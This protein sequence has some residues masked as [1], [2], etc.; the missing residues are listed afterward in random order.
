MIYMCMAVFFFFPLNY[1]AIKFILS[2][3]H[4]R[5]PDIRTCQTT[6]FVFLIKITWRM[7]SRVPSVL[8]NNK[9]LIVLWSSAW[10]Q[11][12]LSSFIITII[13]VDM[14]RRDEKGKGDGDAAA[15]AF[16]FQGPEALL[17]VH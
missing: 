10:T 7:Q 15:G 3:L 6:A 16:F 1:W 8:T 2:N 12:A 17:I 11:L 5:R 13:T 4:T 9:H 14:L